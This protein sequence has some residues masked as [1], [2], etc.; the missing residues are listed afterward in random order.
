MQPNALP[1]G[2]ND[3]E[4]GNAPTDTAHTHRASAA[5]IVGVLLGVIILCGLV[6]LVA[7]QRRAGG[8]GADA[9]GAGDASRGTFD[10]AASKSV[11]VSG[12]VNGVYDST[13][14]PTTAIA[15][16]YVAPGDATG[17]GAEDA[18]VYALPVE[19]A[20]AGFGGGESSTE[21]G[22]TVAGA[23]GEGVML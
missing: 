13:P 1:T 6:Y 16:E 2:D 22:V 14:T 10:M 15:A 11:T 8:A 17:A 18:P 20:F 7:V 3:A 19:E 5:E 12:F 21:P 9:A 23:S 4:P